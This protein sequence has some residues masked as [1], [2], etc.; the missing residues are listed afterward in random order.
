[1]LNVLFQRIKNT[2]VRF[3][4]PNQ[5]LWSSVERFVTLLFRPTSNRRVHSVGLVWGH[6]NALHKKW[7]GSSRVRVNLFLFSFTVVYGVTTGFGKFA[8]VVIPPEKLK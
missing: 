4:D 5:K 3:G 1:M 7:K 8:R 6:Q 2:G